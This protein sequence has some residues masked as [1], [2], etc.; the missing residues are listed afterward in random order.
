MAGANLDVGLCVGGRCG[1]HPLLDLAG[2]GQEG[3][4]NVAGILGRCLEERNSQ[5]VSEFLRQYISL[6]CSGEQ[7][8][9]LGW[10]ERSM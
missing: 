6:P 4:L 1:A 9:G 2:H 3:L 5:A 7:R 8:W 10:S